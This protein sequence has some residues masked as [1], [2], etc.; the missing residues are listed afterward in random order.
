MNYNVNVMTKIQGFFKTQNIFD[1]D[2]IKV[3]NITLSI[4]SKKNQVNN[5]IDLIN[6]GDMKI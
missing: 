3:S 5:L 2:C 1:T 6:N 4:L